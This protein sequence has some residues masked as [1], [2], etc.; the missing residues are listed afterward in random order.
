MTHTAQAHQSTGR[1]LAF[2]AAPAQPRPTTMRDGYGRPITH[3]FG[4]RIS[5]AVTLTQ[6][7]EMRKSGG[8]VEIF[9]E[10]AR[11]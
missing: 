9:Q 8:V 11:A 4:L 10:R 6:P 2:P 1:L 3:I 7:F 5:G